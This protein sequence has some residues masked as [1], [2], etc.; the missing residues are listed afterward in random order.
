MKLNLIPNKFY[1]VDFCVGGQPGYGP[2][3][4]SQIVNYIGELNGRHLFDSLSN[5]KVLGPVDFVT[6]GPSERP[7]GLEKIEYKGE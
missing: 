1:I 4:E 3:Y 5:V 2:E 7:F 6:H